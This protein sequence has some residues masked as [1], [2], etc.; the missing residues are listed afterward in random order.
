MSTKK[1]FIEENT[2]LDVFDEELAEFSGGSGLV[3]GLLN[4]ANGILPAAG[5][6]TQP[7]TSLLGGTNLQT[8]TTLQ[9]PVGNLGLSTPKNGLIGSLM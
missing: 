6:V 7:V 5:P 1:N 9:T 4:T 3:G 8:D 2:L